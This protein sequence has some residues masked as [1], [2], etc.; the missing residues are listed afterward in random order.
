M[1]LLKNDGK[2]LP[3]NKSVRS[4]A[5]IG[6]LADSQ[7]DIMGSWVFQGK[8]EEAVSV[9]QG[10]KNKLPQANV[11]FVRGAEIKRPFPSPVESPQPPVAEQSGAQLQEQITAAVSA[12]RSAEVAVIVLG[13][14]QNMSGE[15][16]SRSSL[17]LPGEQ[18]KLLEAVVGTGKPV[19]LVLLNGR[20]LDITWA[21]EH[22]SA[23]LEAWYP[24][25]EGGNAIADTLFGDTNPGGKLTVSWPR[26]ASQEPLYYA[27]NLTQTPETSAEFQ[28]RFH[29]SRYW[30]SSSL[31]L[32][33]FG[34]GLSYTQ[35]AYSNLRLDQTSIAPDGQ[36]RASIDVQ[37]TGNRA[38][39]EVVQ[40]YIH[41]RAGS[42]SRPV[43][44]LKGFERITLAAGEKR[45]VRF[46]LGRDELQFWSPQ[47]KQW[48][49]EPEAF[50]AWIG[51]D[52]T[53]T[54]HAEFTVNSPR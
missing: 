50:D 36:L 41:Q 19:V 7:K 35:F 1:V 4:V 54:N 34:Y 13:E 8:P 6:T 31:P 45:T 16:A 27:H 48:V 33:P 49:V 24:G 10:I 2:I 46:A 18:Q 52:S 23:I 14:R 15:A 51:G 42:A 11:T 40:L 12:A 32:F 47:A 9:L 3:L 21:S 39:D 38:G 29:G 37:N 26:S 22:V 43:R 44:Q 20:P 5:V 17:Q 25:S 30:D 28:E 53:A